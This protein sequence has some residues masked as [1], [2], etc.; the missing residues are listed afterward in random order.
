[1]LKR[2]LLV[3][4]ILSTA[5]AIGCEKHTT[6]R[7]DS[8]STE[9]ETS[10]EGA[11]FVLD[12]AVHRLDRDVLEGVE[13]PSIAYDTTDAPEPGVLLV[14][15]PDG[16]QMSQHLYLAAWAADGQPRPDS[17]EAFDDAR[18]DLLDELED[19]DADDLILEPTRVTPLDKGRV[20]PEELEGPS[21]SL[22]V[23]SLFD[24]LTDATNA[25][26]RTARIMGEPVVKRAILAVDEST[27]WKT[28]TR[29]LYTL[30]QVGYGEFQFVVR[31]DDGSTERMTLSSPR[32]GMARADGGAPTE[33]I[34]ARTMAH[35]YADGVNLTLE[36]GRHGANVST[37]NVDLETLESDKP[38]ASNETDEPPTW[39]GAVL[40]ESEGACPTAGPGDDDALRRV[41][42][43]FEAAEYC[44][45]HLGDGALTRAV[46]SA[47]A[48][49]PF[50]RAL[51]VMS[52]L[53]STD[54]LDAV[55]AGVAPDEEDGSASRCQKTFLVAD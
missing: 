27:P 22:F 30:G 47:E 55:L 10:E 41:V 16:I 33:S 51:A 17:R 40:V 38:E 1:M 14:V 37:P 46:L 36:E 24:T 35:V 34:C 15:G 8:A 25:Y 26:E 43:G 7:A 29:L 23:K 6:T 11:P 12:D 28:L 52:A 19:V 32:I 3:V 53:R 42:N 21:S 20:S 13:L 50:G 5:V 18:D 45:T 44:R 54:A 9:S 2:A 4:S 48:D 31:T 49:I 39:V